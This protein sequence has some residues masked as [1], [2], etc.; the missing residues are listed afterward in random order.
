LSLLTVFVGMRSKYRT[1]AENIANGQQSA[2]SVVL[3]WMNSA[4]NLLF[5]FVMC[6]N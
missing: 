2:A 4:G 5:I 3:G 6:E 1:A